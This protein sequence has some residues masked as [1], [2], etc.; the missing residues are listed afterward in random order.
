MSTSALATLASVAILASVALALDPT[1]VEMLAL[2]VAVGVLM[3]LFG[4]AV[5]V[6]ED[7]RD[8]L[9]SIRRD[10][11]RRERDRVRDAAVRVSALCRQDHDADDWSCCCPRCGLSQD[12]RMGPSDVCAACTRELR[13]GVG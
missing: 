4:V 5:Q 1:G 2:S 11:G 10:V 13:G 12:R 8:E 6:L 9:R 7:I 3:G